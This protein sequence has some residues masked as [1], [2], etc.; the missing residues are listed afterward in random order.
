ML[1]YQFVLY[2]STS[3]LYLIV[4]HF[5]QVL[6]LNPLWFD[7]CESLPQSQY[8]SFQPV[9]LCLYM[10]ASLFSFVFTPDLQLY[11]SSRSSFHG[12][13]NSNG[14]QFQMFHLPLK[15]YFLFLVFSPEF[16]RL[17]DL[18]LQWNFINFSNVQTAFYQHQLLQ[19]IL[20]VAFSLHIL[21]Y[22]HSANADG[23]GTKDLHTKFTTLER[24]CAAVKHL[25]EL[26][27]FYIIQ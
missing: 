10:V 9:P 4:L 24:F 19:W 17:P 8:S 27:D 2:Y 1:V 6:H 5:L 12:D 23:L 16:H 15:E 3:V 14:Q 13:N 26:Y 22:N 21:N 11:H 20:S 18:S 25:N 7:V